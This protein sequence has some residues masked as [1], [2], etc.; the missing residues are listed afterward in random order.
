MS[1][2]SLPSESIGEILYLLDTKDLANV[3]LCSRRFRDLAEPYL[4]STVSHQIKLPALLRTLASRP[5][6]A[7]H[8][9]HIALSDSAPSM[10]MSI[11][12]EADLTWLRG[13]LP[14]NR[15]GE[16]FC[17]KWY[18]GLF[19]GYVNDAM[20]ALLLEL[21][22]T[23]LRSIESVPFG[24]EYTW[25]RFSAGVLGVAA[26]EQEYHK[27]TALSSLHRVTF[28]GHETHRM[29]LRSLAPY[30][31]LKSVTDFRGHIN[32]ARRT[33]EQDLLEEELVFHTHNV[34]LTESNI[35]AR[36][37]KKFLR[38]FHSLKRFE[39]EQV[40]GVGSHHSLDPSALRE[41]LANSKHC[42]EELTISNK[43]TFMGGCC[44]VAET[45]GS[46]ADF[47]ILR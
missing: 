29:E 41:G 37:L 10:D 36:E 11:L 12:S 17:R 1:S 25:Y 9:K 28:L 18:N 39:Y 35:D 46:L 34:C 21:F 3:S 24:T 45:L 6:L 26:V 23:T 7:Q 5:T 38:C 33:F 15:Y 8:V 42:L 27:G 14:S 4:Y 19:L 30:L 44:D 16:E 40:K 32:S 2:G 20:F 47:E 13:C 31:K 22:S 43:N